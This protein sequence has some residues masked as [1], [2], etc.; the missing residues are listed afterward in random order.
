MQANRRANHLW[1]S[2][3][4]SSRSPGSHLFD[5]SLPFASRFGVLLDTVVHTALYRNAVFHGTSQALNT[6]FSGNPM[7]PPI[8]VQNQIRWAT[9]RCQRKKERILPFSK[10]G[11]EFSMQNRQSLN[12]G[13]GCVSLD[14]WHEAAETIRLSYTHTDCSWH[15]S[16]DPFNVQSLRAVR[17]AGTS[18]SKPMN[19]CFNRP[20][21]HIAI[22]ASW[23][24]KNWN[25]QLDTV[26]TLWKASTCSC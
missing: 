23:A 8:Q 12:S 2:T 24:K 3:Y 13:S 6:F 10:A 26:L 15:I 9:E 11:S 16:H 1:P 4:R 19:F 20:C 25:G 14:R 7:S 5:A 18:E 22:R 21:R 17:A